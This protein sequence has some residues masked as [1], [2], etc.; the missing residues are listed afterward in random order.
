L[1]LPFCL[2]KLGEAPLSRDGKKPTLEALILSQSGDASKRSHE[3]LLGD[4]ERI[5]FRERIRQAEAKHPV[6]VQPEQRSHR[7]AVAGLGRLHK[8]QKRFRLLFTRWTLVCQILS[9]L[10]SRND[11]CLGES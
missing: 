1:F 7:V 6:P 5:R 4:I 11:F 9:Q 3:N 8:T 2:L 10:F